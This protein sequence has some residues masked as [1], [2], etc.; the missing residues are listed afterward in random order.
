MSARPKHITTISPEDEQ[1]ILFETSSPH[2]L[3][4]EPTLTQ[5]RFN[6]KNNNNIA[7]PT[8]EGRLK[9]ISKQIPLTI[10]ASWGVYNLCNKNHLCPHRYL[11]T[12]GRREA[13]IAKCLAQE[14]KYHD[15]DLNP[16][17]AEQKHESLSS[18]LLSPQPRHP[19]I[20]IY[21]LKQWSKDPERMM[22]QADKILQ[23]LQKATTTKAL[24]DAGP[25][26]MA[27]SVSLCYRQLAQSFEPQYG[28]FGAAPKFPQPGTYFIMVM[29]VYSA[30][31][32]QWLQF[33]RFVNIHFLCSH[34]EWLGEA[35]SI[36]YQS[37][38][39]HQRVA[40]V[41]CA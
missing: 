31:T 27:S 19:L 36:Q 17:S 1:S 20:I 35:S 3:F 11:F 29:H 28:G 24:S 22:Q 38:P 15:Q 16:H 9:A 34:V 23:A 10:S 40:V 8:P 4:L 7:L 21:F 37:S 41:R 14:H 18:V 2:R 13:I 32:L 6:N 25:L 5:K 33:V 30:Q 12:P 26:A 39:G